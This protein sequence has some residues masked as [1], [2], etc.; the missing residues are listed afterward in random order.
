MIT[1]RHDYSNGYIGLMNL[2]LGD[3][4]A[5]ISVAGY[6][7]LLK[8]E[9]HISLICAKKIAAIVNET[10]ADKIEAEIVEAFKKFIATNPL[11]DY[12]VAG[13]YRLVEHGER[14]TLIAMTN[15][16]GI[17]NFFAELEKKFETKLP[18]QPTHITLYTLQPEVGIGILSQEELEHNSTAVDAPLNI[19][20]KD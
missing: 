4:P 11:A 19:T 17:E 12:E 18:L 15:V 14:V 10:E 8:S 3:L 20:G 6:D 9:F 2:D 1:P 13:E 16:P 5:T 7:L